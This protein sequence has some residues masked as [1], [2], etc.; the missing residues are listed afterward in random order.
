M[1]AF[2]LFAIHWKLLLT[3]ST[4]D[5][6]SQGGGRTAI[7]VSSPSLL[8]NIYGETLCRHDLQKGSMNLP[9]SSPPMCQCLGSLYILV[10]TTI[11]LGH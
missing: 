9:S 6:V 5:V 2:S 4:G 3:T 11:V 1:A 8:A 10:A 7:F